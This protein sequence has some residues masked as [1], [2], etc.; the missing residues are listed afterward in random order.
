MIREAHYLED[1]DFEQNQRDLKIR[2]KIK[3]R[4]GSSKKEADVD[5]GDDEGDGDVLKRKAKLR[6]KPSDTS[7]YVSDIGT[8][9]F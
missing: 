9:L 1:S 8:D 4:R 2:S 3:S 7:D 6:C 5:F